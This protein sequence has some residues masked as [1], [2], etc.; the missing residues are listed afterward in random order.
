MREEILNLM[1]SMGEQAHGRL[2][3]DEAVLGCYVGK[4]EARALMI[5]QSDNL[6]CAIVY[7]AHKA[8]RECPYPEQRKDVLK[9][10]CSAIWD[11]WKEPD[12]EQDEQ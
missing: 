3:P 11:I 9:M 6:M 12:D 4:D 10:I 5:G 1:Q 7:L 8:A 2:G